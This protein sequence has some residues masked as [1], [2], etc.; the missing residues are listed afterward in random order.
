MVLVRWVGKGAA[1][2]MQPTRPRISDVGRG[3]SPGS[4][5]LCHVILLVSGWRQHSSRLQS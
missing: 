1:A 2:R 5:C 4:S 3:T